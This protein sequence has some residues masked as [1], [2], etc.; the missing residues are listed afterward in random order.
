MLDMRP[1]TKSVDA[2]VLLAR[3][4][5]PDHRALQPG[6]HED[7]LTRCTT[8]ADGKTRRRLLTHAHVVLD[9]RNRTQ[10]A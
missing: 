4:V 5:T 3:T 8:A 7:P 2:S 9:F 10:I 6:H 1:T